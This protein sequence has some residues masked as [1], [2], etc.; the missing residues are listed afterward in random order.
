MPKSKQ[1]R[2]R[3][4]VKSRRSSLNNKPHIRIF[5]QSM[6]YTS[7]PVPGNPYGRVV[8]VAIND[9]KKMKSVSDLNKNGQP[10][11]NRSRSSV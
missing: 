8:T 1:T 4:S 5:Q 6:T 3:S 9:G 11:K 7:N 10:I 2:K